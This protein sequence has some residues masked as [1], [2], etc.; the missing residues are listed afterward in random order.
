[1]KRVTDLSEIKGIISEKGNTCFLC[2]QANL[3]YSGVIPENVDPIFPNTVEILCK[4]CSAR[5][6]KRPVQVYA[7]QRFSEVAAEF[8]KL[9][10]ILGK[11]PL[12]FT[13]S[14]PDSGVKNKPAPVRAVP[15]A[16]T[17]EEFAAMWESDE[18]DEPAPVTRTAAKEL[19]SDDDVLR[20]SPDDPRLDPASAMFDEA[21][22][23]R[24]LD[25]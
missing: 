18:D 8:A 3:H 9:A 21:L 7:A 6:R 20:L 11:S 2:G 10:V 12:N 17:K 25:A 14:S 16:P 15:N 5:R 1:M 13:E 4:A 19:V 23:N 22:Y 24:W